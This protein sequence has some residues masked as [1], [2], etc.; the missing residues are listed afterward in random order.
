M[1]V[2]TKI[3]S[4]QRDERGV[5]SIFIVI[6]AAIFMAVITVSFL[7]LMVHDQ[8]QATEN[9][10]SVTAYDSAMSGI[11][12]A[13]RAIALCKQNP[14]TPGL[15]CD[16]LASGSCTTL[17]DVGV[18]GAPQSGEAGNLEYPLQGSESQN[19]LNQAYTCV[20]VN[21][22]PSDY[23]TNLAEN[24]A[25][26]IPLSVDHP[27]KEMTISWKPSDDKF[28]DSGTIGSL[29]KRLDWTKGHYPPMLRVQ[30]IK[31][32]AGA[33]DSS[34]Q[35][36][37]RFLYPVVSSASS[38]VLFNADTHSTMNLTTPVSCNETTQLCSA[39]LQ[40]NGTDPIATDGAFLVVTPIYANATLT[41]ALP[42]GS[43]FK[44]VQ[45]VVDSTGRAANLFRR[46]Q[47]NIDL[48]PNP[49]YPNAELNLAGPLC[50]NFTVTTQGATDNASGAC[51]DN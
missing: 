6:F 33:Q 39:K 2:R 28:S 3:S 44:G 32:V 49:T 29:Y 14:S 9:E 30:L 5:V 45:N 24:T 42:A 7:S 22:T 26:V 40:L 46:V 31:G 4:L 51:A 19:S 10:L 1:Q 38:T 35:T 23:K 48:I 50:K 36:A 11:E 43:Q 47:A 13:K 37:T 21:A 16:K 41:L 17:S 18:V 12:D 15:H 20:S 34:S 8:Q 27:A 25:K